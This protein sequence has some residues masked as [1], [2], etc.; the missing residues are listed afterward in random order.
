MHVFYYENSMSTGQNSCWILICLYWLRNTSKVSSMNM[1]PSQR[2]CVFS[3]FIKCIHS[4]I[5]LL[6]LHQWKQVKKRKK[7]NKKIRAK[8]IWLHTGNIAKRFFDCQIDIELPNKW[9]PSNMKAH[10]LSVTIS[11][12]LLFKSKIANGTVWMEN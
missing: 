1:I 11:S 10:L 5:V 6:L 4:I 12:Y 8:L 9:N 2:S 7:K 3:S